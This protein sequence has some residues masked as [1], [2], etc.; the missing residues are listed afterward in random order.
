MTQRMSTHE[1]LEL[2]SL[3][4]LGLLSEEERD[5]FDRAFRAAAPALQAQLRAEQAR[6]AGDDSL[7]PVVQP[8]VG[9]RARVMAAVREAVQT[10]GGRQVAGRIAPDVLP[11]R[12]VSPLWRAAA[13]GCLAASIVFAVA[14][15]QMQ[16]EYE[17]MHTHLAD[18]VWQ[19][20]W[21]NEFGPRFEQKLYD[22][23]FQKVNFAAVAGNEAMDAMVLVD[24]ATGEA[25]F[26]CKN[27]P[28]LETGEYQLVVV[29]DDGGMRR[30]MSFQ[31]TTARF[32]K[33]MEASGPLDGL[34][35]AVVSVER[36]GGEPR[37][38]LTTRTI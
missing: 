32:H 10:V 36:G 14:T 20:Q 17:V 28:E 35:L 22:P 23:A 19:E 11:G 6:M 38:L 12:G 18:G 29:D 16:R 33:T 2:A 13:I 26:L 5:G 31:P 37:L 24:P 25:E 30:L 7:L 8:P 9:L 15:L 1:L 4:A 34:K 21:V 3:D 27:L